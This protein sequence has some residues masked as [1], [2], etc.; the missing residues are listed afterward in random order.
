MLF[1]NLSYGVPFE[2]LKIDP[3]TQN[4]YIV[5]PAKNRTINIKKLNPELSVREIAE[6]LNSEGFNIGKTR[7]W[8]WIKQMDTDKLSAI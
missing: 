3:K 4:N 5:N 1:E 8:E 2:Q 6:K 7:V